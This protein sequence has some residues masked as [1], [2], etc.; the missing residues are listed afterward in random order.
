MD[1]APAL[2][3]C[4]DGNHSGGVNGTDLDCTLL[5]GDPIAAVGVAASINAL[6]PPP[7]ALYTVANTVSYMT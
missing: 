1:D 5:I 4:I 3:M 6:P 7:S 2:H